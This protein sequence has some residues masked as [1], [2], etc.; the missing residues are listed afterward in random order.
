MENEKQP[1]SPDGTPMVDD[2]ARIFKLANKCDDLFLRAVHDTEKLA[3]ADVG[4]VKSGVHR[5]LVDSR[6]RF[7]Y[8][9]C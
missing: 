6:D 7:K 4:P 2:E 9:V 1:N 3:Q 8:W 5:I